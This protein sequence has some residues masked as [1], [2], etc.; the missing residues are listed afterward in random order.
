MK[1]FG[2]RATCCCCKRRLWP[3]SVGVSIYEMTLNGINHLTVYSQQRF[4]TTIAVVA[5]VV[6]IVVIAFR[7]A[8][9]RLHYTECI[10]QIVFYRLF[11]VITL[12]KC[13]LVSKV[14]YGT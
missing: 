14:L 1:I 11:C 8:F 9:C 10:V 3:R 13:I 7:I 5:V 6:V 2:S 12:Y 4:D